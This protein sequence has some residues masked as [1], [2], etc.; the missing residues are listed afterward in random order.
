MTGD[1]FEKLEKCKLETLKIYEKYGVDEPPGKDSDMPVNKKIPLYVEW[2]Q[3]YDSGSDK[4]RGHDLSLRVFLNR[5]YNNAYRHCVEN[6]KESELDL[7]HAE[8][9]SLQIG[10]TFRARQSMH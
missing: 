10:N 3:F 5:C 6:F 8:M 7:L 1:N 4:Y 2:L 9:E